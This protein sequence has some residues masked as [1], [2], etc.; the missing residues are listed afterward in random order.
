MDRNTAIKRIR[1]GLKRRSGKPWSVKGGTG[2]AWGWLKIGIPPARR[3]PDT[4]DVEYG[5]LAGLLGISRPYVGIESVP[6]AT[7]YYDEY[8]ARAEGRT[9]ERYGHQ[10]WD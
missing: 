4:D 8:V 10:Y 3:N 5:E 1:A 7:D 9:P 6:A 2:T